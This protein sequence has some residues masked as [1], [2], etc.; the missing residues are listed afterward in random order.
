MANMKNIPD[1]LSPEQ[2]WQRLSN[3]DRLP[4]EMKPLEDSLEHCLAEDFTAPQDVP[5]GNRSFMDGY[6]VRSQDVANAPARLKLVGEV[7]MGEMLR[8]TLGSGEAISIPTGGFM[9]QGSDAVV[10]QEDCESTNDGITV[11]RSVQ[12]NENVQLRAEDFR[13]G[14]R[15]SVGNRPLRAQDLAAMATFGVTKVKA[16]RKPKVAVISTGN[17]LVPYGSSTIEAAQI[18]ETNSLALVSAARHFGFEAQAEGIVLD[19]FELQREALKHAMQTCDVILVS[20]GSSVGARDYTLNVIESFPGNKIHFHGL[21]IRPGNPTIAASIGSHVVFG[22]PGQPVSS[23]IVFYML[24]LPCLF[25]LSGEQ[26][27][28][29]SFLATKFQSRK[30]TLETS[31]NP[32]KT[33]TDYLRVRLTGSNAVPVPGKSASLSTLALADGFAV[34]PPGEKPVPAGSSIDVYLFP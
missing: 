26:I 3:L 18:R 10:M 8:Q 11:R 24:V 5:S 23:L 4:V 25:H 7:F 22:L 19:V 13:A 17:E 2:A 9:P 15:I 30:V 27:H 20:G 21:A 32:L 14:E 29:P 34:I 6:A 28:Y 31:M 16:Y 33:K 12:P 1:S